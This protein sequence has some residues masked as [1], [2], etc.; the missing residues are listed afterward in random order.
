MRK[1]IDIPDEIYRKLKHICVDNDTNPKNWIE[2][3]IKKHI[4]ESIDS[5]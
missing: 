5:M 2:D 3:L 1:L 4:Y